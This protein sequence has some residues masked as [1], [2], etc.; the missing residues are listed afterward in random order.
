MMTRYSFLIKDDEDITVYTNK[1]KIYDWVEDDVFNMR[2]CLSRLNETNERLKGAKLDLEVYKTNSNFNEFNLN[3]EI[4]LLKKERDDIKKSLYNSN[5]AFDKLA[6]ENEELKKK[7]DLLVKQYNAF[8]IL[9]NN[10]LNNLKDEI[11]KLKTKNKRA[12]KL[13]AKLIY[14]DGLCP[15][16]EEL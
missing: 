7:N 4:E 16:F 1:V 14:C 8:N 9:N 3:N 2:E 11:K 13:I 15:Y 10:E 12:S 5:M 6:K